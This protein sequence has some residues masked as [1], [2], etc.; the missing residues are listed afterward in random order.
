MT[1]SLF[2]ILILT[3]LFG[4]SAEEESEILSPV[5]TQRA[6][7]IYAEIVPRAAETR[8]FN[9]KEEIRPEEDV[10]GM[11]ALRSKV[12]GGE[13]QPVA[14]KSSNLY[15]SYKNSSYVV[16]A[17]TGQIVTQT[18]HNPTVIPG[19]EDAALIFYS[20]YPYTSDI[21]YDTQTGAPCIPITI[22]DDN[23][24]QTDYLYAIQPVIS[25]PDSQEPLSLR[26]YHA[27]SRLQVLI[28]PLGD[29]YDAN[30][31]PKLYQIKVK[32][33]YLQSGVMSFSEN[34]VVF[35]NSNTTGLTEFVFNYTQESPFLVYT[36]SRTAADFLFIPGNNI[37]GEIRIT[38]IDADGNRI[39]DEMIYSSKVHKPIDMLSNHIYTL[40][41]DYTLRANAQQ[42]GE[43][44]IEGWIDDKE[45]DKD[46]TI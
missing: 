29:S 46:I 32:T 3:A 23:S 37:I 33:N 19:G 38:G 4:C 43:K 7:N 39:D 9:T 30:N 36:P 10:L 2:Y 35:S 25:D 13:V 21:T 34:G 22:T 6:I 28:N 44:G 16:D 41:L 24:H 40:K 31:C 27:L 42:N 12:I 18:G 14:W 5:E 1:K 11:F 45:N 15:S 20:Y 26:Y 8:A 17:E